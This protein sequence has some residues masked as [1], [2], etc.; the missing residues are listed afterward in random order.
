MGR[1]RKTG[2]NNS[3]LKSSKPHENAISCV[4][5]C[6]WEWQFNCTSI[7]YSTDD[8]AGS[9]TLN[10]KNMQTLRFYTVIIYRPSGRPFD[11]L[12]TLFQ[13]KRRRLNSNST[14]TPFSDIM[15]QI[16]STAALNY[17]RFIWNAQMKCE[18]ETYLVS[19]KYS[20]ISYE[21]DATRSWFS[22]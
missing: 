7:A 15:K 10:N 21:S 22:T 11:D 20:T 9:C 6:Q 14:L 16:K 13:Y 19:A 3:F 4:T 1:D 2:L 17:Q 5:G 18:R 8:I 12:F